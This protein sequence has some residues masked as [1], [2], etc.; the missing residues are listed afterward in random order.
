MSDTKQLISAEAINPGKKTTSKHS[1]SGNL[2][3][4]QM[5]ASKWSLR[6]TI[7]LLQRPDRPIWR[8]A[9]VLAMRCQVSGI[10][11]RPWMPRCLWPKPEASVVLFS[12]FFQD[13][14]FGI[15]YREL[16]LLVE[17]R[18]LG[19]PVLH[20]PWILVDD[21]SAL[22]QGRELFG[23]PKKLAQFSETQ[24]NGENTLCVQRRGV[25][26]LR[27]RSTA[28]AKIDQ[29]GVFTRPMVNVRGLPGPVPPLL[30]R[31]SSEEVVHHTHQA[32]VSIDVQDSGYD[33]LHTLGL[34]GTPQECWQTTLDIAPGAQSMAQLATTAYPVG[35]ASPFWFNRVWPFRSW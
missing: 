2:T 35:I 6:R 22:L 31:C 12:A 28:G 4:D 3:F 10:A 11:L 30:M 21:D 1:Y 16:G 18:Y 26:I 19:M 13:T 5:F 15:Q 25:E 34:P 14:S 17:T 33:P 27:L 32:K 23:F 8:A 29:R 9:T 24:N 7:G 20:V